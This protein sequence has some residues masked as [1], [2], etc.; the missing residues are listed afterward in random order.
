MEGSA[1]GKRTK[2]EEKLRFSSNL[3]NVPSKLMLTLQWEK[4]GASGRVIAE[5]PETTGGEKPTVETVWL[6]LT[7]ANGSEPRDDISSIEKDAA[8]ESTSS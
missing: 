6:L 2:S 3:R 8:R 5:S 4:S 7:V 1:Q